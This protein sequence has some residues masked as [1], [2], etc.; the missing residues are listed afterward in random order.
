MLATDDWRRRRAH[1][2]RGHRPVAGGRRRVRSPTMRLPPPLHS[3]V[4]WNEVSCF[5]RA[6]RS[7]GSTAGPH[8]PRR[9][10]ANRHAGAART[11]SPSSRCWSSSTPSSAACSAR[12]APSCR[13]SPSEEFGLQAYTAGLTF[14]LV[15]GLAKAV[16]NYFAG[17]W[18]DRYGRKPVL[19]AG[20]AG[21]PTGAADADLGPD[22]GLGVAANVLLG[23]SQ[24][25]TWSTTVVMKI[26][27]VGPSRRGPG[28]GAQRGRRV[29]RGR[30]HR[31]GHRL[32]RRGLRAAAGA[33]LPR[34]RLRRPRPRAVHPGGAGRPASTPAW[35]PPATSPGPTAG[36]TTCTTSSAT[37]RSSRRPAS[38]SRR[39]PRRARR[40]W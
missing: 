37:G 7:G 35:R 29:R 9:T 20:L 27:L 12:S 8:P 17:T 11:T 31:P 16:T 38:R 21:R 6:R 5:G 40:G 22:L 18:S 32:P 2:V 28:D 15:F 25:L 23:I 36:T 30:G 3:I 1:P 34:H 4:P 26:D 24:G 19:V 13:C 33:V 14:I 39:S 10:R